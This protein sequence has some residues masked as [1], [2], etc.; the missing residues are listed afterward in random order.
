MVN[1]SSTCRLAFSSGSSSGSLGGQAGF[2]CVI[3]VLEVLPHQPLVHKWVSKHVTPGSPS[4]SLLGLQ[5]WHRW[6]RS[7]L[8]EDSWEVRWSLSQLLW[9]FMATK[10][11]SFI[12]RQL[13]NSVRHIML[14]CIRNV[15]FQGTVP[16]WYNCPWTWW[17]WSAIQGW[18]WPL[19]GHRWPTWCHSIFP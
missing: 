9:T 12:I 1:G 5:A 7:S 8:V 17:K 10:W 11:L 15:V 3:E 19:Q 2:L 6:F 4:M 14:L 13:V 16:V 18:T